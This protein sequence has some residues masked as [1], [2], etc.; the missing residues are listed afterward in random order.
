MIL[1]LYTRYYF[2]V[3]GSICTFVRAIPKVKAKFD[4]GIVI[5]MLTFCMVL[6][7]GYRI[8][9][10]VTTASDRLLTILIGALICL[11]VSL[12]VIPHWAGADLHKLV[13][14]NFDKLAEALTGG[15]SFLRNFRMLR[16][17][18]CDAHGEI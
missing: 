9:D 8:G 10:E 3:A 7:I 13:S 15:N 1:F 2:F 6:I 14:D 4:Y 11:L 12:I 5:F 16:V 18:N 17:E